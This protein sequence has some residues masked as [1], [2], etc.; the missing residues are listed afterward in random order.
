MFTPSEPKI[1]LCT[2]AA[3]IFQHDFWQPRWKVRGDH[4]RVQRCERLKTEHRVHQ[5]ARPL[6]RRLHQ[7]ECASLAAVTLYLEALSLR[8]VIGHKEV[9]DLRNQVSTEIAQLCDGRG[10]RDPTDG[11]GNDEVVT[12]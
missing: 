6:H 9:F 2:A 4:E 3:N 8:F 1:R 5:S 12:T 10:R 7:R 11:A